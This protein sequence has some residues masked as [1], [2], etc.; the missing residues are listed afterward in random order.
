MDVNTVPVN[1]TNE[2]RTTMKRYALTTYNNPHD[3]FKEYVDWWNFD[4]EFCSSL[5]LIDSSSYLARIAKT[6]NALSDE[7]NENEKSRAIDEIIKYDF[8]NIYRKVVTE[9]E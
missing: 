2:P 5:G 3:P 9:T 4:R 8:L 7:E 6:S 1:P